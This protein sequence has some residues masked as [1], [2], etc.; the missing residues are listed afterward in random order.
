MTHNKIALL[1]SLAI[2]TSLGATG[3]AQAQ[4]FKPLKAGS[5]V[6]NTRITNV[7]PANDAVIFT[8]A[9]ADSGLKAKVGASTVPTVGFTYFLSD[10]VAVE[11]ILGTS[12]HEIR[13]QGGT[14]DV[15]V[16]ETWVLP[17]VVALQ[18][19]FAPEAKVNPYI[20]A[21]LNAMVFHSGKDKNGFAVKLSNGGGYALQAGVDIATKGNWTVNLDVKK[22][23]F[24]T[25]AKINGGA[26]TSKVHLDPLVVSAGIGYRF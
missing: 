20:G 14:T 15:A 10:H 17:P 25:K 13:A 11:A 18:Y 5:F 22:I 4:D 6:L 16:H 24:T 8:A 3:M 2:I 21:G 26:L 7:A 23:Y 19:H 9:G 12:K 1:A